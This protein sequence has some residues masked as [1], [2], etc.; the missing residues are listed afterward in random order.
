MDHRLLDPAAFMLLD[1]GTDDM[2]IRAIHIQPVKNAQCPRCGETE[3]LTKKDHT[4]HQVLDVH[5]K[6]A[7]RV[8]VER[9]RYRCKTCGCTFSAGEDP[10]PEKAHISSAFAAYLAE[11][12]MKDKALTYAKVQSMFGVS[13][14]Y[15]SEAVSDYVNSFSQSMILSLQPCYR[16]IFSPFLYEQRVRC[17]VCGTADDDRNVILGF[18]DEYTPEAI[19]NF[20]N[21][22]LQTEDVQAVFCALIPEMVTALKAALPDAAVLVNP[23]SIQRSIAALVK[24]IGD[25]LYNEKVNCLND[26]KALLAVDYPKFSDFQDAMDQWEQSIPDTL[27]VV[28]YPL[29]GNMAKC[30]EECYNASQYEEDEFSIKTVMDTISLF[31]KNNIPYD[32][33]K[34]RILF[35]NPYLLKQVQSTPYG[36]YMEATILQREPT[37]YR[38]FKVDIAFLPMLYGMWGLRE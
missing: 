2:D 1:D 29:V 13:P 28:M 11:A 15:A 33:M 17:C 9:Q 3:Q 6:Q 35:Q 16:V 5:E 24:D 7:I 8:T 25:G 27:Q 38:N 21:S 20:V 18:L 31:R 14:T 4:A 12:M 10:Y 36:T 32:I 37:G 26:L 19:T 30:L 23:V 34:Y 22:Q